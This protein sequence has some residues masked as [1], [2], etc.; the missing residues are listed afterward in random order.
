MENYARI[1]KVGY[2]GDVIIQSK[3]EVLKDDYVDVEVHQ[4]YIKISRT[5]LSQNSSHKKVTHRKDGVNTFGIRDESIP[6][7]KFYIDEE[8]SNED[9][10]YINLI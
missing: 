5:G 7:G 2:V 10:I 3:N 8:D 9:E 4:D 6:Q 1:N